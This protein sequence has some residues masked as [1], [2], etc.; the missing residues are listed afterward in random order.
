MYSYW[1]SRLHFDKGNTWDVFCDFEGYYLCHSY[2]FY[3][4]I[5]DHIITLP[6]CLCPVKSICWTNHQDATSTVWGRACNE[7]VLSD[8]VI[9]KGPTG[10]PGTGWA[11]QGKGYGHCRQVKLQGLECAVGSRIHMDKLCNNV[12]MITNHVNGLVQDC[13][14]CIANALEL[15][16]SCAEPSVWSSWWSG[17][18][19]HYSKANCEMTLHTERQ[20]Q[21]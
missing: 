20:L 13:I 8:G 3:F 7:S 1:S 2:F 21:W 10:T 14:N 18:W 6:G 16:Q 12:V 15:L 17:V 19:S 5:V 9:G 11:Q 4:V